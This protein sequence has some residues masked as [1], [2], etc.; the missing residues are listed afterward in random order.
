MD[1]ITKGE[2]EGKFLLDCTNKITSNKKE[3]ISLFD[4]HLKNFFSSEII[5][6]NLENKGFIDSEGYILYDPLYKDAMGNNTKKKKFTEKQ[7]KDKII[8][9]MKDIKIQTMMNDKNINDINLFTNENFNMTT[10]IKI[11]FVKE[12]NENFHNKKRK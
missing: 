4:F 1:K 9:E 6:K 12:K 2:K 5:R 7:M 8:S 3:Y 11:P 10:E